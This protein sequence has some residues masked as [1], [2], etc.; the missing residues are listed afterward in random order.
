MSQYLFKTDER[1]ENF[2]NEIVKEMINAFS[3]SEEEALG[4]LNRSWTGIDTIDDDDDPVYH[5][6][7]EY[8]AWTIYYGKDSYWWTDPPDLKPLAYP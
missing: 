7:E 5:E 3:I 6:D 1:G 4:R 2:C 8:W